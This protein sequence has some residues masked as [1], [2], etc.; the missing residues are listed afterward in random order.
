MVKQNNKNLTLFLK[1]EKKI[2]KNC[3]LF[4]FIF[5]VWKFGVKE[6]FFSHDVVV[7]DMALNFIDLLL[8]LWIPFFR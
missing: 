1:K 4:Y 8:A 7:S 5:F 6:D 3:V 2:T